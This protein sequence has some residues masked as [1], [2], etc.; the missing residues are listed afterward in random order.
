MSNEDIE[1]LTKENIDLKELNETLKKKL[2]V[3]EPYNRI[4]SSYFDSSKQSKHKVRKSIQ[5]I[6][7]AISL[8]S[9]K[10]KSNNS[11]TFKIFLFFILIF[12]NI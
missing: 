10:Y 7:G 11:Y 5:K 12:F 1:R 6:L 3:Y 8:N 9:L 4:R 2:A